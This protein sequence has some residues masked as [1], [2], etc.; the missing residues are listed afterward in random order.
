MAISIIRMNGS[1]SMNR[2][3]IAPATPCSVTCCRRR[4]TSKSIR[5]SGRLT[6]I[7]FDM[8]AKTKNRKL[9]PYVFR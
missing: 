6:A 9:Q 1:F 7:D 3:L 2:N 4:Q 8:S 5:E